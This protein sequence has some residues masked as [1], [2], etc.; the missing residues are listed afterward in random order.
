[1]DKLKETH[2]NCIG[3][4]AISV[5]TLMLILVIVLPI[6]LKTK[7]KNDFTTKSLPNLDNIHLWAKFPGDLKSTLIHKY[8]I[9]DYKSISDNKYQIEIKSNFSIEEKVSYDNFTQN[10]EKNTIYF[11]TNRTYNYSD[12]KSNDD[13][14]INSI[15]MG[16]FETLES[17]TYPPLHKVGINSINYLLTRVLIEPDLFI[18]EL[19][20]YNLLN[21]INETIITNKILKNIPSEKVEKIISKNET[22]INYSLN[23]T[24]GVFE[25]VK[26]M[27][28]KDKIEKANWLSDLFE[29][30]QNEISSILENDDAYLITEYKKYN[31][32]LANKF[33]CEN[34]EKCGVELLY[35][36]FVNGSVIPTLY[37]E[38]KDYLSLNNFLETK[39]Y[40]FDKTPEM[41]IYFDNEFIN[42]LPKE[43]ENYNNYAPSKEQLISLLKKDSENCLLS[44]NNS[45][46]FIYLN[47]TKDPM[48][49]QQYYLNLTNNKILFLTKYL[50]EFLPNV[51]LY[52][53]INVQNNKN[54]EDDP[55]YVDPI[56]KT[57]AVMSQN[58]ADK[59]YKLMTEKLDL[60]LYNYILIESIKNNLKEKT[61]FET[62]DELCPT[63]MQMV[64][65]DGK[66]VNKICSDTNISLNSEESLYNWME[67]FYC[68][69]DKNSSKCNMYII[70]YLKDLVYITD[71]EI[72]KIFSEDYLGGAFK[73]GLESIHNNYNCGVR[74][75]EKGYLLKLQYWTGIVTSNP[76]SP[77]IKTDTIQDWF[78]VKFEYPVE[79]SY[80]IKK[81]GY[82]ETITEEDIDFIIKLVSENEDK[83]DLENSN[84]L[85]Q[86]IELEKHYSLYIYNKEQSSLINLFN[87]LVDAL[88]FREELNYN[89]KE[90]SQLL[91]TEYSSIKN[92]IQG[93]NEEDEKWLKYLKSGNYFDNF[94][95]NIDKTT[96][97]DIG[98]NLDTK[99]Q[100]NF[101]FDYYG[102]FTKKSN[103]DKRKINEMNNLTTLNI[104]KNEYDFLKKDNIN[105]LFP[106][107]DYESLLGD[108][109]FSDGFQ[110]DHSLQ[111]IYFYDIISSRPLRFKYIK[112][113]DYKD[114]IT[115]RRYD[116]DTDNLSADMNEYY[117]KGNKNAFIS[118]KL[119]KPYI[120]SADF[121][122]LKKYEYNNYKLNDDEKVDNY[123]C[124][125]PIT[126]MVIDS[127]INLIY[128][129][130][131]R[132]YGFINKNIVNEEIYPIFTY[133]RKYDVEVNSYE[134]Q[135]PG[136]TEYNRNMTVFIIIGVIVI[137]IFIV[138]A[139]LA[140]FYLHKKLHNKDNNE[141]RKES[142]APL[143]ESEFKSS[144]ETGKKADNIN[145][146][147]TNAQ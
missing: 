147:A 118:Q 106:L 15:N 130:Y 109:K 1:M 116:L 97:L 48:K 14:K 4:I 52:P 132:K 127:N 61:H 79:I 24:H 63:L 51:L 21:E 56:A 72:K 17:M 20:T 5:A 13:N 131:T 133:Q 77:F 16:L 104:K 71:E 38:I 145:S 54:I 43:D 42:Y 90:I 70:D 88:V 45:I 101:D 41:K 19:F 93:N 12:E 27:G 99:E 135:F 91:L 85:I 75:E 40:P 115:C 125:D 46:Y 10:E 69:Y 140:F 124:L 26:I 89:E 28:I 66:K 138:V 47:K 9:F 59:T 108:R 86:Q 114:K 120:I 7:Q 136:I 37:P 60:D 82:N 123:I 23:S 3:I 2:L 128:A 139:V 68:F 36:H 35:E 18:R 32:E 55:I 58:I 49:E 129:I 141:E 146:V 81:Y 95:P 80:Y 113:Q 53:E 100:E 6:M 76:P 57:V 92:L 11:Y 117:D 78:P 121:N 22:Y 33:N 65:D 94:K 107:Y 73:Y 39:F 122:I 96:E 83:Y 34:K 112:E 44:P 25:W 50:Y 102:I 142:L 119:N 29:L 137:I 31:V 126:D 30:N 110:Y 8:G 134:K 84:T 103:Y 64:L 67:P 143:T 105:L 98:I 111:V 87:F 74:C 144:R 62:L